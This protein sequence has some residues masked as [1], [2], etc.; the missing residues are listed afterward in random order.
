MNP[1]DICYWTW[2]LN[3]A[4]STPPTDVYGLRDKLPILPPNFN[5][6]FKEPCGEKPYHLF[7]SDTQW[8]NYTYDYYRMVEDIDEH[9][10]RIM[11]A[12]RERDEDTV[13]VFTSDHGEGLARHKRV[14]KWHPYHSSLTVPFIVWSPNRVNAGVLDTAHLV[15]GVDI[16]P[17]FCDFAGIT[18]PPHQRGYSLRPLVDKDSRVADAWRDHIYAEYKVTGR[19][20]RTKKY[21]YAM[22]YEYSGNVDKPYVRKSDGQHTQFVP[23]QGDQYAQCPN[24]LLFDLENDPWELKNLI[25]DPQ[26]AD[27]VTQHKQLL[28][29]WEAKLIPGHHYDRN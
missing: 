22:R 10:G 24:A 4:S 14:Q 3:G 18:P 5:Y 27:V 7:Q 19:I 25:D 9:V 23:G 26:R 2:A 12:V 1:H 8:R 16:I 28:A 15:S 29:E 20:I 6:H 13:V 21:K 11:D 17:T